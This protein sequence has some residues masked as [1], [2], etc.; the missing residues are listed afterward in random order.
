M[1]G[2]LTDGEGDHLFVG[3]GVNLEVFHDVPDG[4]ERVAGV[5]RGPHVPR[6][7][8]AH[9]WLALV[10]SSSVGPSPLDGAKENLIFVRGRCE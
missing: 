7:Q 10:G 9:L 1:G 4:V 6:L 5:A 8:L 3:V 2:G